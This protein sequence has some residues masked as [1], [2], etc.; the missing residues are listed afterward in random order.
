MRLISCGRL[1]EVDWMRLDE[2]GW[3]DEVDRLELVVMER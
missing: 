3:P 1:S 2:V